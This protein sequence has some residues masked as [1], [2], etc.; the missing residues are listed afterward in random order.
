MSRIFIVDDDLAMELLVENLHFRGHEIERLASAQEALDR[1][2]DLTSA[3]LVILDIIMEWPDGC[4]ANGLEGAATAGMEVLLEI[5]KRNK[6]LPVIVYSATQNPG[7]ITAI[8]NIPHCIFISK[9]EGP[10]IQDLINRI[11]STLG[12][13]GNATPPQSFI[14]HGHDKVAKLELKN[15]LQNTLNFPEPIILHE[16]PNEGR[17]IIEKFEHY[18]TMSA[19][20]FVLLTPDDITA[21]GDETDDLKRH[22]RQNV[23]F[24][25]GYFLGTLGRRSGRVMLLYQPPLDLP[26]DI[27]GVVY[28][29]I[30]GGIEAARENIRKEVAYATT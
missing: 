28:I 10:S 22:A 24:E 12:L 30:S 16:Q 14:V 23:I 5:R 25:M 27:S 17:T 2:D 26:S 15:F 4:L 9:W 3:H 19:V 13:E 1:V 21:K 6:D 20:V 8:E 29:D 7:V 18:A 11:H